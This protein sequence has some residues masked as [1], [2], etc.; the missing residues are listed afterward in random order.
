MGGKNMKKEIK[1]SLAAARVNAGLTQ[2]DIAREMHI[3]KSTVVNWE[4][5]RITPK[6]AQFEKFCA[7]CGIDKDYIFLQ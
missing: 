7:L 2:S 4:K 3:N 6:P 1:I 5:G